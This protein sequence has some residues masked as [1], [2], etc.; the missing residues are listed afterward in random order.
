MIASVALIHT[1]GLVT[2][3]VAH[4]QRLQPLGYALILQNWRV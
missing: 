2:G 3:N 1:L 4:Y